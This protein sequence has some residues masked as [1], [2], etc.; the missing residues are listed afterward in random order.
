MATNIF[1]IR[2]HP[3]Q[4]NEKCDKSKAGLVSG[5]SFTSPI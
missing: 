2:Y 1:S 3:C 5:S 4:Y